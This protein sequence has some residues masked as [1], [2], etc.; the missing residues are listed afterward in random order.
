M[1]QFDTSVFLVVV[2]NYSTTNIEE[3]WCYRYSTVILYILQRWSSHSIL[4]LYTRFAGPNYLENEL[5]NVAFVQGLMVLVHMVWF[6]L[7]CIIVCP[8]PSPCP[9]NVWSFLIRVPRLTSFPVRIYLLFSLMGLFLF[10]DLAP[11]S[12][13]RD[14][15]FPLPFISSHR[16]E[17]VASLHKCDVAPCSVQRLA[18]ILQV[19]RFDFG[20]GSVSPVTCTSNN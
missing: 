14:L 19:K 18:E 4:Q 2:V 15:R 5:N 10:L 17:L 13:S 16:D 20:N 6:G 8:S 7:V 9:W 12:L 3:C 1:I 11:L